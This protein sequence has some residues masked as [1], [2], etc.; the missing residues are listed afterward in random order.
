MI[1]H[2][3]GSEAV[4][5]KVFSWTVTNCGLSVE[6]CAD[7]SSGPSLCYTMRMTRSTGAVKIEMHNGWKLTLDQTEWITLKCIELIRDTL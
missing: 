4:G 7:G 2:M 3:M 1:T 6:V 5:N